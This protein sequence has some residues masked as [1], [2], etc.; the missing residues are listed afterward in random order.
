MFE[1]EPAGVETQ[2]RHAGQ[3]L[4]AAIDQPGLRAPGDRGLVAVDDRPAELALGRLFLLE[5]AGEVTRLRLAERMLL[6]ERA[7][8][9]QRR[10]GVR[11]VLAPAALP[12]VCPPLRRLPRIPPPSLENQ[13][14]SRPWV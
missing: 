6:P 2:H 5:H 9:V 1:D 11:V 14:S 10:D 13:A 12:H 4:G 3:V 7:G 8:G